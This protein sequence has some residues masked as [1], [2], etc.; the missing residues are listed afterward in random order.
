M[1]NR[2]VKDANSVKGTNPQY[3]IEKITRTRIYESRYW[4]E[5]CFALSAELLVDKAMEL[6]YIGGIFGGNVKPTP[7]LCLILKMLQIQPD[8]DIII[9]FIKNTEFKYVRALGA[10][11]MRITGTSLD[12]YK[13]LEPLYLDYR[14][15]KYMNRNGAL[16]LTYMDD[17]IDNLIREERVCDVIMPRIQKRNVLE[18]LNQLE[19]RI[20]GL[21]EEMEAESEEEEEEDELYTHEREPTP[22]KSSANYRDLDRPRSRSPRFRRSRSPS[23]RKVRERRSSRERDRGRRDRSRS[24][25]RNRRKDYREKFESDRYDRDRDRDRDR[26]ERPYKSSHKHKHRN[27]DDEDTSRHRHHKSKKSKKD[28]GR[29]KDREHRRGKDT[30]ID[31]ANVIRASLGL[32][33]LR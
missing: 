30:E 23:P 33:P 11:Y 6:K 32:G 15:M 3:L 29:D 1:A 28:K 7:F 21:D 22:V 31:Q 4:K 20:S 2:T 8:K 13:Y 14:K 18:E 16:E 24:R 12:C 19:P 26:E 5:E 9:E 27:D 17:F 25:D 10:L